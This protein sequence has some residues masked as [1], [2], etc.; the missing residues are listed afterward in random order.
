MSENIAAPEINTLIRKIKINSVIIQLCF[1]VFPLSMFLTYNRVVISNN[2]S[3]I[4]VIITFLLSVLVLQLITKRIFSNQRLLVKSTKELQSYREFIC[5]KLK[6][7]RAT[8][9]DASENDKIAD[10]ITDNLNNEIAKSYK[11]VIIGYL[12][13]LAVVGKFLVLPVILILLTSYFKIK[14]LKLENAKHKEVYYKLNQRRTELTKELFKKIKN[15]NSQKTQDYLE[16]KI[17]I[18]IGKLNI[19]KTLCINIHN[20]ISK[21]CLLTSLISIVTIL[22]FGR[23]LNL[24]GYLSIGDIISCSILTMWSSR[25]I[26]FN[27]MNV[28]ISSNNTNINQEDSSQCERKIIPRREREAYNQI[29]SVLENNDIAYFPHEKIK[30]VEILEMFLNKTYANICTVNQDDGLFY[31]TVIDNITFFDHSKYEEAYNL[32]KEFQQETLVN[33]LPFNF[34]YVITGVNDYLIP[35][36]LSVAI[37]VFRAILNK[38]DLIILDI[39]IN[40]VKHNF[41]RDLSNYCLIHQ[42]KLV[43]KNSRLSVRKLFAKTSDMEA[44]LLCK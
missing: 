24:Y 20:K 17:K 31:G 40:R 34:N 13:F 35:Y 43:S 25:L 26:T 5:S 36:D 21:Y 16:N 7:D 29:K 37:Y 8:K 14:K 12:L 2:Y 22:L 19:E 42:I 28:S 15:I 27:L 32:I 18:I 10:D 11:P 6:D 39:D 41:M 23:L 4:I 38:P 30:N 9:Y 3:T 33:N 44:I 1:L